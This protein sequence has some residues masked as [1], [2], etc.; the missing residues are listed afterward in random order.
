MTRFTVASGVVLALP[1]LPRP[2]VSQDMAPEQQA[3][4]AAR[5]YHGLVVGDR[6][7]GLIMTGG[8]SALG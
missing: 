1:V 8:H 2:S 3:V 6:L 4:P 7:D 5:I